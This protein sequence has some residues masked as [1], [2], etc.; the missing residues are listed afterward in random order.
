MSIEDLDFPENMSVLFNRMLRYIILKGGRGGAKSWNVA[1]ALLVLGIMFPGLRVLCARE[2]MKSIEHSVMQLLK[3]QIEIMGLSDYYDVQVTRIIGPGGTLFLFAGLQTL[4]AVNIKSYESIDICWVEEAQSVKKLSWQI[5]IPTIRKDDSQIWLSFNPELDTDDTYVRFVENT[6]PNSAVVTTNW[7]DNPWFPKTLDAERI[8]AY[9]TL[10]KETYDHIWEGH[11]RMTLAGAIF[12]SEVSAMV[13]GKRYRPVPYDPSRPVH[14]AWD[15]GWNDQNSLVFF[16]ILRN[17]VSIID[18]AEGSFLTLPEWV[19]FMNT[20]PYTYG[21]DVMPWDAKTK[22][23]QT[24]KSD[25]GILKGL[26]RKRFVM[27]RQ[28]AG[29]ANNRISQSRLMFPRVYLDNSPAEIV[30]VAGK[31]VL[32]GPARLMECMKRYSR[33]VPTTTGE[34]AAPKH[35]EFCHGADA[36]GELA[37][38][39]DRV[40]NEMNDSVPLQYEK[41]EPSVKGVM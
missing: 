39:V 16:Q 37:V 32:H 4:N 28:V 15:M 17:E 9:N 30:E 38:N 8:H 35:D 1:R 24:G 40:K 33:T 11:P 10:D 14:V 36:F 19:K 3:D 25:K 18:Y 22:S 7:R 23:R 21:V 31:V 12:S 27:G 26:G 2:V 29:A 20:L 6:P 5:L 34:P 41:H 13:R